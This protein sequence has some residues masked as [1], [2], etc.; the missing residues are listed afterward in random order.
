M[1]G[2]GTNEHILLRKNLFRNL[3]YDYFLINYLFTMRRIICQ[4]R[5]CA[6]LKNCSKFMSRDSFERA[7]NLCTGDYQLREKLPPVQ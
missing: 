3:V 2:A 5:L 4:S 7:F 6:L 1:C